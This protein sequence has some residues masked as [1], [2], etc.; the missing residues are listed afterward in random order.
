MTRSDGSTSP[1]YAIGAAHALRD[2]ALDAEHDGVALGPEPPV[3]AYPVMYLKGY[4]EN[5]EH[6][7]HRCTRECTEERTG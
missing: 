7:P 6:I 1:S 5:Y 2:M 4:R 3:P